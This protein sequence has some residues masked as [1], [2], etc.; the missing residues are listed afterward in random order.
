M[1][2][3]T[4]INIFIALVAILFFYKQF[5]PV[6]GVRTLHSKEFEQERMSTKD[7]IVIDVREPHEYKAGH[8]PGAKNLPLSQL[9]GRMNELPKD[10]PVF[11]YC[12]SGMRSKR[13]AVIFK[14]NGI[15]SIVNLKGGIMA[16]H[17]SLRK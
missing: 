3:S 2:T 14:K 9:K 6:K 11:V 7:A 12:Q 13:A 4:M 5:A 8:M 15:P 1:D 17:N 16:W 10:K